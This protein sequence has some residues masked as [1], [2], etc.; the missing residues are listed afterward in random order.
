MVL[1]VVHFMTKEFPFESRCSLKPLEPLAQ[2]A[3]SVCAVSL[4]SSSVCISP[5][6]VLL[7]RQAED[8]SIRYCCCSQSCPCSY[9]VLPHRIPEEPR[10]LPFAWWIFK[11]CLSVLGVVGDHAF[12]S[13]GRKL[14]TEARIWQ[15]DTARTALS[16]F[17][18]PAV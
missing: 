5:A 6:I 2:A 7:L 9:L 8:C 10:R 16:G 14:K 1:G 15:L 17:M 11:S 4:T 3:H 13:H 12:Q 18:T